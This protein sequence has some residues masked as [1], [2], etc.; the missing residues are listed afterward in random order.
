MINFDDLTK[1]EI[2]ELEQKLKKY[3]E[4]EK[5]LKGYEIKLFVRYNTDIYPYNQYRKKLEDPHQLANWICGQVKDECDMKL[6]ES[7]EYTIS[8][9]YE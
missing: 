5:F 4:T 3:K 9:K 2:D 6:P 7:V 1:E 8:C